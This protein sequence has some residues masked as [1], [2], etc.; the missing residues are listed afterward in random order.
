M[1]KVRDI[2][3]A[4]VPAG[5]AGIFEKPV[6]HDDVIDIADMKSYVIEKCNK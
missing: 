3:G 4:P 5:L 6:K 2:T 1:K